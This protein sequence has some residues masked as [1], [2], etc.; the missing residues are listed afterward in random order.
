VWFDYANGR[1]AANHSNRASFHRRRLRVSGLRHQAWH[2]MEAYTPFP[3]IAAKAASNFSTS[4]EDPKPHGGDERANESIVWCRHF[5]FHRDSVRQE[6]NKLHH[7]DLHFPGEAGR[8]RTRVSTTVQSFW[9]E[10]G[11]C[12]SPT[13][14]FPRVRGR[15]AHSRW[16]CH[17]RKKNGNTQFEAAGCVNLRLR[18]R[19]SSVRQF[20][21][22]LC[23]VCFCDLANGRTGSAVVVGGVPF[24]TGL[25]GSRT[26][27]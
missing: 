20:S 9:R 6:N 18:P 12:F 23:C 24:G 19:S 3:S 10:T 15:F 1:K 11:S 17:E 7:A 16:F 26:E 8:S 5:R 21:A 13:S 2:G 4:I 22:R 25:P 14:L 27:C